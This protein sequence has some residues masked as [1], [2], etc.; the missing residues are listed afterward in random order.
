M[1]ASTAAPLA[2]PSAGP[3]LFS[4]FTRLCKGLALV[5]AGGYAVLQVFPSAA[6]YLALIPARTIP[7]GWNLLTA[8]YIEQSLPGVSSKIGDALL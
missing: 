5:L 3:G 4:G 1:L 8:G 7:F 2:S 6:A